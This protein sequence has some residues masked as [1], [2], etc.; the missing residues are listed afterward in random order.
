MLWAWTLRPPCPFAVEFS[1]SS[2]LQSSEQLASRKACLDS[3]ATWGTIM[4]K[5]SKIG[6]CV[7]SL[8]FLMIGQSW[9]AKPL[10]PFQTWVQNAVS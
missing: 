4:Y 7:N 1:L 2:L 9:T 6:G 5:Y 10:R 3:R 8:P